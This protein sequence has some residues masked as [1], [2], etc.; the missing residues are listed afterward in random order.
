MDSVTAA[1]EWHGRLKDG[2]PQSIVSE[3][4]DW[5]SID[6]ANAAAYAEV[7]SV[8]D[9]IGGIKDS[10]ELLALRNEAL[11]RCE[12]PR[13][14][15]AAR[16]WDYR[17]A[18]AASLAAIMAVG[19][20]GWLAADK[21]TVSTQSYVTR[22]GER[23]DL[24]LADGSI[25]RLNARSS[26]QVTYT[27]TERSLKLV[28]GQALF[29]VAKDAARPFVVEVGG[30]K[31]TAL[32]TEFDVRVEKRGGLRVALLEGRLAVLDKARTTTI[33]KPNDVLQ[34]SGSQVSVSHVPDL[35]SMTSWTNGVMLFANTPLS[36]AIE[37]L[38]R[39]S[40]KPIVLANP[41]LGAIKVSGTF[42]A[43]QSRQ[44]LEAMELAFP[45]RVSGESDTQITLSGVR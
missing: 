21:E 24:Q 27:P 7:E 19:G 29:K 3:F 9:W 10:P 15:L 28:Q 44:F 12:A 31:I 4:Q 17:P 39:Y 8:A 14:G 43:G 22:L 5:Q 16:F 26:V 13:R 33:L 25:V 30:E 2:A 11:G 41:R 6:P 35:R 38:N 18:V 40:A 23:T 1:A 32:G 34:S 36:E 37:E 20:I 45:V 42:R